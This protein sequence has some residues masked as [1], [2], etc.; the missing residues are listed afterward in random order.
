MNGV[1]YSVFSFVAFGFIPLQWCEQLFV[2]TV[3][4]IGFVATCRT[5][6]IGPGRL[7][8]LGSMLLT[9]EVHACN[10]DLVTVTCD[11]L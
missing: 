1:C 11:H 9:G 7:C 10:C 6:E 2:F 8:P 3:C 4:L 5:C